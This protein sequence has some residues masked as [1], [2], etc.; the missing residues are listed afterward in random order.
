MLE[1]V[2]R[3]TVRDD[4]KWQSAKLLAAALDQALRPKA[5]SLL[6]RLEGQA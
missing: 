1:N 5:A 2:R 3:K 6:F 4:C